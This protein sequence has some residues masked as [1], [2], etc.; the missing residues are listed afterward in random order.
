VAEPAFYGQ[1]ARELEKCDL[2]LCEGVNAR[3]V[4][5]FERLHQAIGE[6]PHLGLVTQRHLLGV[7]GRER[8]KHPGKSFSIGVVWGALHMRAAVQHLTRRPEPGYRVARG[9]WMTVFSL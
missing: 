6:S 7:F 2:I 3:P 8:L 4:A 1:V 5:H 9:E